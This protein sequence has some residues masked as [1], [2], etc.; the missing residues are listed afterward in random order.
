M[1]KNKN[2]GFSLVEIIV[3]LAIMAVLVGMSATGISLLFSRDAEK[4][5][6]EIESGLEKLRTY[7]MS[8]K[9]NWHMEIKKESSDYIMTIYRDEGSGAAPYEQVNL[10]S[11]VNLNPAGIKIEYSRVTGGVAKVDT[12]GTGWSAPGSTV[13]IRVDSVH[14]GRSKTVSIV[15]LTGRHFIEE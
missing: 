13:L 8:K 3:V 11:K 6:L 7:T 14:N 4:C 12:T 9:G 5:A 1:K 10:G 15:T 2:A